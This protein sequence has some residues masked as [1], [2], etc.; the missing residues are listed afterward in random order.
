VA[1]E[2][3]IPGG[4]KRAGTGILN[5]EEHEDV[6]GPERQAALI[7]SQ[8]A[9]DRLVNWLQDNGYGVAGK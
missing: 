2:K 6:N 5:L 7:S 8:Q 3:K 4:W 9:G 1:N